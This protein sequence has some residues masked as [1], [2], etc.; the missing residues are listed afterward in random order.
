MADDFLDELI[1]GTKELIEAK[2]AETDAAIEELREQIS[3]IPTEAQRGETGEKGNRGE[4]GERGSQGTKGERGERGPIG[5]QGPQG[6]KGEKGD[7]GEKG[8]D[9]KEFA[10]EE[11]ADVLRPDILSRINRGSGNLNRNIAVGG[12]QSVLSKYTDIN[13][14]PGSNVTLSYSSNNATRFTDITI[15]AT[16][17]GGG[18]GISRSVNTV[19]TDTAAGSA[20][21]TDYVYLAS[22]NLTI[23]LPTSIGN[24]NLYTIKNIG[25][26]TITIATTGGDTIDGQ[27]N[28]QM[29]VQFTSVDLVSNNSGNWDIT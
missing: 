28:L 25:A 13:F 21:S 1:E 4:K 29:P 8:K 10:L 5:Y 2:G 26:G 23:T 18:G 14:I 19:A 3:A 17:G 20:A 9:A 15:A 16:G 7:K 12:N 6:K 27:V 11:V 24:S 22:G